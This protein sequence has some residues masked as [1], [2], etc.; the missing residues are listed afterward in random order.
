MYIFLIYP[1]LQHVDIQPIYLPASSHLE[2]SRCLFMVNSE[3]SGCSFSQEIDFSATISAH[4]C[5]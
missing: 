1:V 2:S 5:L 3:S 4:A